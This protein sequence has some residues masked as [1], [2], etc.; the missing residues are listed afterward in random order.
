MI[1][2]SDLYKKRMTR[3]DLVKIY[4]IITCVEAASGHTRA[5][6]AKDSLRAGASIDYN[7]PRKR[8]APERA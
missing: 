1:F 3:Y 4:K 5:N 7:S 8:R 6:P 2:I